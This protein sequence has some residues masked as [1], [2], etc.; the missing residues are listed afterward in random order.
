MKVKEENKKFLVSLSKSP[1]LRGSLKNIF[2]AFDDLDYFWNKATLSD[3]KKAGMK[4]S[5]FEEFLNLRKVVSPEREE[6]SL[7][8]KD[9][10]VILLGEEGYPYLLSEISSPPVILFVRGNLDAENNLAIVGTRKTTNYGTG[11]ALNLAEK[12]AQAGFKIVSGLAIGIDTLAHRGAL[13][14]GQKTIAVLGSGVDG[15]SIYP[16]TNCSLALQILESGG[17]LIS[18]YPPGYPIF[19]TNFPERNRIISGLSKGVL[20]IEAKLRSGA[21]ITANF[22][23]EQNREVFAVPG[24]INRKE[25]EGTNNL[26]KMG[27]K[28]VTSHTDILEEF[29]MDFVEKTVEADNLEEEKILEALESGPLHIDLISKKTE[30]T[31]AQTS[32]TLSL[33]EIKGKVFNLGA[34][35]FSIKK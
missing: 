24:D 22:A 9:I 29:G 6:E 27:A 2:F 34:F 35:N 32:A 30:L 19:K 16:S 4:E 14:M 33:M 13:N 28:A 31:I 23:L 7:E 10:K 11:I 26:V 15:A 18:E 21:L 5:D 25:S 1:K 8:Q 17:A 20:V 3:F 12:L